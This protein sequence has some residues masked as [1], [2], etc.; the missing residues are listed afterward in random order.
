MGGHQITVL[1]K[2]EQAQDSARP[3]VLVTVQSTQHV[4]W[5]LL[6]SYPHVPPCIYNIFR[7]TAI[8]GPSFSS[9]VEPRVDAYYGY[10]ASSSTKSFITVPMTLEAYGNTIIFYVFSVDQGRPA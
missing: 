10:A 9:I 1:A 7:G 8:S 3:P 2:S 6:T 5:L 4:T